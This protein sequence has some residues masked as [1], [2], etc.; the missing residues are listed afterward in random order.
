M[1]VLV[2][3]GT[4]EGRA[5]SHRLDALPGVEV[6]VSLA[7]RTSA[8]ADHGGTVRVG[9]FGGVEGLERTLVAE[10]IDA[11]VDATHPFAATISAHAAEAAGRCGLPRLA[12]ERPPWRPRPGDRWTDVA[13]VAEAARVLPAL[14][15]TRVLLT[16]G[17]AELGAFADIDGVH[18]VVRSIEAVEEQSLGGAVF[19]RARGLFSIADELTLLERHH[20][21][22]V[23]T[24][25]SG[26]DDAKL[27]AARRL[28]IPVVMVRRPPCPGG[29]TVDNLD[30]ALRWLHSIDPRQRDH[31]RPRPL[32]R[33]DRLDQVHDEIRP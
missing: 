20:I 27:V 15:A 18:F 17:R 7:G 22:T 10:G 19:I 14:G 8:V 24:K 4:A 31:P 25:N 1:K 12:F 9:G 11:I 21:D 26:G 28:D 2:L 33:L 29:T 6:V 13:D 32:D 30:A 16:I 5:L 3:A 23:V